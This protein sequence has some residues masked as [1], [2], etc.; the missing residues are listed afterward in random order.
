M[1]GFLVS[2]M[3]GYIIYQN[4]RMDEKMSKIDERQDK[5]EIRLSVL[6]SHLPRRRDDTVL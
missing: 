6:E 5:I 2:L 3:C 1:E 4:Q